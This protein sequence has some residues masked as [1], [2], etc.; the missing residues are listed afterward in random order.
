MVRTHSSAAFGTKSLTRRTYATCG[1][2]FFNG[3][4]ERRRGF[5]TGHL[6][7]S[8]FCIAWTEY[9]SGGNF[10]Y[11]STSTGRLSNFTSSAN[12]YLTTRTNFLYSSSRPAA[13]S[14]VRSPMSVSRALAAGL[15]SFASNNYLAGRLAVAAREYF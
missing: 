12:A 13:C 6:I 7:A 11:N 10:A 8:Y 5:A 1:S 3:Q 9:S 15:A 2:A 14:S 4:S